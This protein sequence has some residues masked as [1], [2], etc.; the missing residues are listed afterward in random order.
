MPL[1]PRRVKYR[2]FQRGKN[3]GIAVRGSDLSFGEFGLKVLQNGTIKDKQIESVRV[4]LARQLRG[5][6]KVWIRIFPH[7]SVTKKPAETRMG[8]GKGDLS[9]WVAQVKRGAILFEL[10]GVP[11]QLARIAFRLCA[12][13]LPLRTKFI[14]RAS[15]I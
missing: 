8:K 15:E 6:G 2:K 10:G 7:K 1:M 12:F 11:E 3:R 14:T 9:Y 13:K 5:S 4:L